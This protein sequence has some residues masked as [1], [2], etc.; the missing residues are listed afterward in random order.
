MSKIPLL[1]SLKHIAVKG[2]LL[3]LV[4]VSLS[5][6]METTKSRWNDVLTTTSTNAG[7]RAG[8]G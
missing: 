3:C 1:S 7:S 5:G 6:C 8:G 4:A 2:A